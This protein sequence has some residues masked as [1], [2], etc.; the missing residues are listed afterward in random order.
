MIPPPVI[1]PAPY[2]VLAEADQSSHGRADFRYTS[3]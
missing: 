1:S 2:A 3:R